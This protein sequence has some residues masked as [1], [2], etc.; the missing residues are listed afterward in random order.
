MALGVVGALAFRTTGAGPPRRGALVVE[1]HVVEHHVD[2][3]GDPRPTLQRGGQGREREARDDE[4]AADDDGGA[5]DIEGYLDTTSAQ[6]GDVVTLFASTVAPTFTV[7]AYR[8]GWYQG[9]GHGW[10]GRRTRLRA[11]CRPG[12]TLIGGDQH[13]R[14]AM[15]TVDDVPRRRRLAGRLVPAQAHRV[16]RSTALGAADRPRRLQHRAVRD[17]ERG[18]S[19][20]GLQPLGRVLALQLHRR[21]PGDRSK[22]VSFDRPYDIVTDGSGDFLGNELPLVMRSEELNLDATYMTS[23]DV[24]ERPRAAPAAP[25]GDLARPRR[26]LVEGDVRRR[27]RGARRR[28]QPRVP[29]RQRGLP[30]GPVRAL[31]GRRRP[32]DGQ[33][34]LD[35]RTRSGH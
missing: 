10:S 30:P 16:D 31:G 14:S 7:E 22:M 1:H 33:L 19:L 28:R 4:L 35:R 29:R 32:P 24:H 15:G 3:S 20:A 26:V 5:H 27:D 12:P 17:R 6:R 8:M 13:L 18:V 11:R 23:I 25:G 21:G 9:T 2:T 34:P